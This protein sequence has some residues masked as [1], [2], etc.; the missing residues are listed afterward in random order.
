MILLSGA[1][2]VIAFSSQ[3]FAQRFFA[4][5]VVATF[6]QMAQL[7]L[8]LWSVIFFDEFI[9]ALAYLA[10]A[11]VIGGVVFLMLQRTHLPHLDARANLGFV[12]VFLSPFFMSLMLLFMVMV[13]RQTHP[14]ATAYFWEV[15]IGFIALAVYLLRITVFQSKL[16]R[17]YRS[18]I[19]LKEA[20]FVILITST[21]LLGSGISPVLMTIGSPGVVQAIMQPLGVVIAVL[22]S[23][24]IFQESLTHKQWGAIGIVLL[25]VV[26][27]KLSLA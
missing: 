26:F 7:W 22:L 24:V 15:S 12:Y 10:I 9:P 19:S 1:C 17:R 5:G 4:V 14:F 2:G 21:T 25:G 27:L 20:G 13:A 16:D 23:R 11:T 8:L 18:T 6:S 3:L